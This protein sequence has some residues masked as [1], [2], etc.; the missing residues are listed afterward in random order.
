MFDIFCLKKLCSTLIFHT[1]YLFAYRASCM[2]TAAAQLLQTQIT[3]THFFFSF[4]IQISVLSL[5]SQNK[6][7]F[8][9]FKI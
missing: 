2:Q 1:I 6:T 7:H 8:L 9:L 3:R 5:A 4:Y